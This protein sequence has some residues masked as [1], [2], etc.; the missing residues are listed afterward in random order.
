MPFLLWY[1]M[2]RY[3]TATY[4]S[5]IGYVVPLIAVI[6]GMILLDEKLQP[7]L[8][9]GGALILAGVILT[10]RLEQRRLRSAR[11]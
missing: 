10:D 2:I 7:G 4:A 11:S 6:V 1:W 3:V 8:V 9:I 5:A